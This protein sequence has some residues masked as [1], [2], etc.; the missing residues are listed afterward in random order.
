MKT[1]LEQKLQ[2]ASAK[3][4]ANAQQRCKGPVT[5]ILS[6]CMVAGIAATI[7]SFSQPMTS[8]LGPATEERVLTSKS[9]NSIKFRLVEKGDDSIVANR[10]T[11]GKRFVITL[12]SLSDA[13]QEFIRAW[14]PGGVKAEPLKTINT[15]EK[16]FLALPFDKQDRGGICVAAALLN[17]I[18]YVDPGIKLSQDELFTLLNDGRSGANYPQIQAALNTLG[19][20]CEEFRFGGKDDE[21]LRDSL[22]ESLSKN[23]PALSAKSGHMITAIGFDSTNPDKKTITIW[24]QRG[25]TEGAT[26]LES[27]GVV[28]LDEK[29][30]SRR[31]GTLILIKPKSGM[32]MESS[33]SRKLAA[34]T[35]LEIV[36]FRFTPP[37]NDE[38]FLKY[39]D[40]SIDARIA[41]E[42]RKSNR[43]FI[44]ITDT[45]IFEIIRNPDAKNKEKSWGAITDQGKNIEL[46]PSAVKGYIK[47][48]DGLF[49]AGLKKPAA[50]KEENK[51]FAE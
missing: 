10:S 40:H 27:L 34:K 41:V 43:V 13:D 38:D 5:S 46:S 1:S 3:A 50:P 16:V 8:R 37:T 23:I 12:D 14:T 24:D 20:D 44:K 32:G 47:K 25:S 9:G 48:N 22:R 18:Q 33:I 26:D 4:K 6:L 17:V 7:A 51:N 21:S 35:G 39:I 2:E 30:F 31:F 28:N 36:S 19:Y 29:E 11:D 15:P 45:T 42:L 49:Y